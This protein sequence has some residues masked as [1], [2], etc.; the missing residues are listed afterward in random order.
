MSPRRKDKNLLTYLLGVIVEDAKFAKIELAEGDLDKAIKY[1]KA[2]RGN[3]EELLKWFYS[4]Q[5]Q[6]EFKKFRR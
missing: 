3:V 1:A 5:V 4:E 6:S 2:I